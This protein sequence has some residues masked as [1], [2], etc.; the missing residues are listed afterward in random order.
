MKNDFKEFL[1]K[2]CIV[3]LCFL[4]LLF[5]FAE[6]GTYFVLSI[7]LLVVCAEILVNRVLDFLRSQK[8]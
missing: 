1:G 2:L 4:A 8:E 5:G 3:L 7:I 6:N